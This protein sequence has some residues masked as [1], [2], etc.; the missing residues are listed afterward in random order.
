MLSWVKYNKTLIATEIYEERYVKPLLN[1][2]NIYVGPSWKTEK[3]YVLEHLIISDD[4]N[5]LVLS[6]RHFYLN[7]VI[8]RL[9]LKSYCDINGNINLPEHKRIVCQ[10]ENLH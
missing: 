10:I 5:L 1:E 4:V 9:N 8:T 6:T 7:A 3:I 2:D